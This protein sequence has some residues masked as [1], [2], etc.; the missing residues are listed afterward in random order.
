MSRRANWMILVGLI[1]L[2]FATLSLPLSC[3]SE[4]P[5]DGFTAE[6]H[7]RQQPSSPGGVHASSEAGQGVVVKWTNRGDIIHYVV[8]RREEGSDSWTELGIVLGVTD[9][10]RR[11]LG[12]T[13]SQLTLQVVDTTAIPGISY[14]YGVSGVARIF[15]TSRPSAGLKSDITA[16]D[17]ITAR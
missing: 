9:S 12:A 1:L 4:E 16:T 2:L 10:E 3:S 8:Y 14:V 6:I 17:P 15:T 5:E 7:A 13:D 11:R